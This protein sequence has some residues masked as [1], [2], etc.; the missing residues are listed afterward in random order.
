[1]TLAV[2][3]LGASAVRA[4][5]LTLAAPTSR[6]GG[7]IAGEQPVSAG[8]RSVDCRHAYKLRAAKANQG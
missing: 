4:Q 8:Y 1:M 3:L 5:S 7:T 6:T 2:S